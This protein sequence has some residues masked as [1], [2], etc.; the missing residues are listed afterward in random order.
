VI[1]VTA[2]RGRVASR[3]EEG[4]YEPEKGRGGVTG[5]GEAENR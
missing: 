2:G 4:K 3:A 1:I 5:R